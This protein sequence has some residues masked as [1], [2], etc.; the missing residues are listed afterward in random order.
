MVAAGDD[1]IV[2]NT[3]IAAFAARLPNGAHREIAG[4]RHELLQEQDAFRAGFWAASMRL[5][6]GLEKEGVPQAAAGRRYSMTACSGGSDCLRSAALLDPIMI[7][8]GIAHSVKIIT[9]W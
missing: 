1:T 8:S 4:A 3:A 6:R 7:V 2:S 9:I 5:C